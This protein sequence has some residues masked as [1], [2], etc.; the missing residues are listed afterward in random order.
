G[1]R[2]RDAWGGQGGQV[3]VQTS[4]N[5]LSDGGMLLADDTK[6]VVDNEV[7]RRSPL[8]ALAKGTAKGGEFAQTVTDDA[9][10]VLD[11]VAQLREF[12]DKIESYIQQIK[13]ATGR[14]ARAAKLDELRAAATK[15]V[16]SEIDQHF[17]N[18]DEARLAKQ[19][20]DSIVS[21]VFEEIARHLGDP[22]IDTAADWAATVANRAKRHLD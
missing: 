15:L 9:K 12:G 19:L 10:A 1:G 3:S 11:K 13:D 16:E 18:Q 20:V 14:D 4:L 8:L 2:L 6:F 7:K 17:P 5:A 22:D 21:S